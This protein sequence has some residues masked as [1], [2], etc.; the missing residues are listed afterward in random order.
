[1]LLLA[2]MECEQ[3][4][5]QIAPDN[6]DTVRGLVWLAAL[7]APEVA[8]PRLEAFAQACLTFSPQHFTYRSLVLGNAAIH[9][10]SLLPGLV[11]VG[12]LT[13]L[14]RRR[15]KRPGEIKTVDKALAVL[16]EA[17]GV[18]PGELEEIGLPDYA[19]GGDGTLAIGVGPA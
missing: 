12:S 16:A 18:T 14:R 2:A 19:F 8:A 13:R 7:A 17:C 3:D 4:A 5:F 9:A 15:L 1:E 10:F 11:G 6:Q